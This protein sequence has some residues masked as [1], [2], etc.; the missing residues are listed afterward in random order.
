[1]SG[2]PPD[3]PDRPL[4]G[5]DVPRDV[6]DELAAH[7]AER[8]AEYRRSGM[9]A[10]EARRRALE[11]FGDL[12]AVHATLVRMD[13][14]RARRKRLAERLDDRWRDVRLALRSLRR[15]PGFAVSAVLTLALG[16]GATTAIFSIVDAVLLRP[17]P[18]R[19][20]GRVVI[21]EH[22]APTL[23]ITTV[24]YPDFLDWSGHT[25]IFEWF[26]AAQKRGFVVDTPS[27]PE[28]VGGAR[29]TA[30]FFAA[31]GVTP[32]LGRDFVAAD[33][34]Y[35]AE[36]IVIVSHEFWAT[37]LGADPAAVGR[38]L[39][40]ADES[41]RLVGVLPAGFQSVLHLPDRGDVWVPLA[42]GPDDE[43][44]RNAQWLWVVFRLR[45]GVSLAQA[46]AVVETMSRQV[47]GSSPDARIR[48]GFTLVGLN[49][50]LSDR[51]RTA[52]LVLFA[53]VGCLLLIGCA[54]V[55]E[56]LLARALAWRRELAV[57]VALGAGRGRILMQVL[58]ESLLLSCA[59]GAAGTVLAW[60]TLPLVVRLSP[61]GVPRLDAA[62][63]DPGVLAF[64]V[65]ASLL[66]GALFGALPALHA[67]RL[68]PTLVLRQSG[69]STGG[70]DNRARQVVLVVEVALTLVLLTAA[71]L[72]VTSFTRLVRVDSGFR[73]DGILTMRVSPLEDRP[74][75]ASTFFGEL[76]ERVARLP[77][78]RAAGVVDYLPLSSGP[79][80]GEA[81]GRNLASDARAEV[82]DERIPFVMRRA[83]A[84][85]FTALRIPLVRGR[86]FSATDTAATAAIVDVTFARLLWGDRDPI[87]R[88]LHFGRADRPWVP[89]V[90]VVG[91]VHHD[92]LDRGASPTIYW[93]AASD[94]PMWTYGTDMHLIVSAERNAAAL[95]PAIRTIARD[96]HPETL[97][98][99]ALT[100]DQVLS[101]SVAA[102]R[103][104]AVVVASFAVA[105]ALLAVIG[106]FGLVA[107]TVGQRTL[108]LGVRMALGAPPDR[109]LR[110][111]V[112]D[113]LKVVAIGLVLGLAG[114]LA[115][116]RVLGSLLFDLSATDPRVFAGAALLLLAVAALACYLPARRVLRVDP[117]VTLRAE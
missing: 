22:G 71:G 15:S 52:L 8:E 117:L 102:P 47:Y 28:R 60:W 33:D 21:A 107:Y 113:G 25:E 111:V 57:R 87:G 6:D 11:R 36:R 59:G 2:Q 106:L 24:S 29:V 81:R 92:G 64:T 49:A 12:G 85:Y 19:D 109:L 7:L 101:A 3:R 26:A 112:G 116:T 39:R 76:V 31:L 62:R 42:I 13:E 65:V 23:N 17:L 69:A 77:G 32:T 83:T 56:L 99:D 37:R 10:E 97:L 103:F 91:S 74:G 114:A 43:T 80:R 94:D 115:V 58:T 89:V 35:G 54:N 51:F 90:G 78:V 73:A 38:I 63:I 105:A 100:M 40:F 44:E 75:M 72:L 98:G 79:F 4:W 55:S 53:A 108:E 95:A 67:A 61:G 30:S 41:Y 86:L 14:A 5:P 46:R 27:G 96:L 18:Y 45:P 16:I 82:A 110:G 9:G 20:P 48:A 93:V 34:R 88:R 104:Y 68:D 70:R 84:G 1:M 50:Y 66:A